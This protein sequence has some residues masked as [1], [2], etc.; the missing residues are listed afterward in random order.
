M[1]LLGEILPLLLTHPGASEQTHTHTQAQAHTHTHTGTPEAVGSHRAASGEQF[2][3][4]SGA[5]LKGTSSMDEDIGEN[6]YTTTPLLFTTPNN[7]SPFLP[8]GWD[9]N[10]P[11]SGYRSNF[12]LN[13]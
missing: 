6:N 4:V 8:V 5:L 3:G 2:Q 9:S 7:Y 10:R 13:L 12:I 11:S 1:Y